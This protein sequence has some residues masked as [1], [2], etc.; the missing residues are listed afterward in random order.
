ML[1]RS[2]IPAIPAISVDFTFRRGKTTTIGWSQE[3]SVNC[4][5]WR[6][7]VRNG[8]TQTETRVGRKPYFSWFF[9]LVGQLAERVGSCSSR[10]STDLRGWRLDSSPRRKSRKGRAEV[11]E[12]RIRRSYFVGASG[13]LRRSELAGPPF[14]F[15]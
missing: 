10:L 3:S 13:P 6:G 8:A 15:S 14:D 2:G 1:D 7:L 9:R 12:L 11:P 5:D 4:F